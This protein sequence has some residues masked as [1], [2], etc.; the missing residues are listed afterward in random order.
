MYIRN[1]LTNIVGLAIATGLLLACTAALEGRVQTG[2]SGSTTLECSDCPAI[3]VERV[4]DGDTFDTTTDRIRLYG[5]DTPESGEPCYDE[6]TDRLGELAGDSVRVEAGPRQGDSYGRSLFY[7]YSMDG[8]SIDETLVREGLALAWTRDG[9]H[10]DVL[11]AAERE[12]K[13]NPAECADESE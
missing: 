2:Q 12:A 1:S 3:P 10:K 13:D 5:I 9:Q 7:V 6:A 11:M 8:E 4:I